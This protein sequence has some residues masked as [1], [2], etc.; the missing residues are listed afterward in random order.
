ML[1]EEY[2]PAVAQTIYRSPSGGLTIQPIGEVVYP[3]G[4]LVTD[5]EYEALRTVDTG[6]APEEQAAA[7]VVGDAPEPFKRCRFQSRKQRLEEEAQ[8]ASEA[9][10]LAAATA[11]AVTPD[12]GGRKAP[13]ADVSAREVEVVNG[14]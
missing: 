12:K 13:K 14:I 7:A 3:S 4:A 11:Q 6:P 2:M 9:A 8:A 1:E 5:E 10:A